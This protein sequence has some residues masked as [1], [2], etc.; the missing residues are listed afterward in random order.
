M[1]RSKKSG[2]NGL[3]KAKLR[4]KLLASQTIPDGAWNAAYGAPAREKGESREAY[5]KRVL[6]AVDT[7]VGG[8]KRAR[9]ERR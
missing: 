2:L 1:A 7:K 8:A 5:I 9:T 3:S 4:E 6:A